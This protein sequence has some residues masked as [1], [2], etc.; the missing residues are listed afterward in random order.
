MSCLIDIP[1]PERTSHARRRPASSLF[2]IG[3]EG[4]TLEEYS[5]LLISEG[6]RA[7]VDVRRN[8]ISRKKGFSKTALCEGLLAN[9]IVYFHLP[10]LGIDSFLRKDLETEDDFK[11]LFEIY[12]RDL[13][14]KATEDLKNLE[15]I[16]ERYS[17]VALTCFE[18]DPLHCHRH[19][20]SDYFYTKGAISIQAAH[21]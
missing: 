20:I 16:I 5:N 21:I 3:Y 7:V 14:P 13:L 1:S 6:V 19:C 8:P 10:A 11:R 17:S 18:R 2:T 15:A 4:R 9:G 12:E